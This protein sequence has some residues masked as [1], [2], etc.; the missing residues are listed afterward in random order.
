MKERIIR[1]MPNGDVIGIYDDKFPLRDQGKVSVE[2]ASNVLWDE[3]EQK[4]FVHL[5]MPSGKTMMLRPGFTDRADAIAY[6][7]A[8][9]EWILENKAGFDP[10]V[11]SV[12]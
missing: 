2:R 1:I 7:V 6:E 10:P 12:R 8:Q 11:I 9:L 3:A 5:N 4:W